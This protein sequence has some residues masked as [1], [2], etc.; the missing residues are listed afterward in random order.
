MTGAF[1]AFRWRVPVEPVDGPA[2]ALLAAK[3]EEL[4]GIGAEKGPALADAGASAQTHSA[5]PEKSGEGPQPTAL[6]EATGKGEP[7]GASVPTT[8]TAVPLAEPVRVKDAAR[9][10]EPPV[11][12]DSAPRQGGLER[13]VGQPRTFEPKIFVS[14]RA[15]DDPGPEGSGEELEIGALRPFGAK[16]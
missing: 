12:S 14:P 6:A 10:A 9:V 13:R 5:A 3:M 15:P 7:A 8:V 1:D 4:V 16:A 11:D 2:G